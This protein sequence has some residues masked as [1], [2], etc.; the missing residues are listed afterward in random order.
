M[1]TMDKTER[2]YV[3]VSKSEKARVARFAS[4]N[5]ITVSELIQRGIDTYISQRDKK[6]NL[7]KQID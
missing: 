4:Q 5:G 6:G 1:Y 7:L 2:L 3:R